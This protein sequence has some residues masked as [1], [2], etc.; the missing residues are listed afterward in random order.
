[1]YGSCETLPWPLS[2]PWRRW[3]G[4][5]VEERKIKE[6]DRVVSLFA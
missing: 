4:R 5:G 2:D 1:M 6:R 3:G